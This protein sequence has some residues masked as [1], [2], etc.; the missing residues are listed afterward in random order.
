MLNIINHEEE[1]QNHNVIH[2]TPTRMT[3]I[4]RS[5]NNKRCQECG[6]IGMLIHFWQECNLCIHTAK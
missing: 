1:D 4:K 6:E 2:F 5:D 3:I